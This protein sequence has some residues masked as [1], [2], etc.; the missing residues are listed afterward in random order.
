MT[1]YKDYK[2][3][4][5]ARTQEV[6]QFVEL[7]CIFAFGRDQLQEALKEHNLTEKEFESD[8][9]GFIG[10]GAIRESKIK[11]YEA[12]CK[13]HFDEL[14]ENLKD[15]DF[16]YSAFY[17]E[18]ANHE[19]G[20]THDETEALIDLGLMPKDIESNPILNKAFCKAALELR[21]QD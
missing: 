14:Q 16:A 13:K 7:N 4:N 9:V 8:F 21:N 15:F 11:D 3:W 1:K 17:Y 12:M 6:N 2:Q 20:Y 10:G 19:Y 5:E 18:L